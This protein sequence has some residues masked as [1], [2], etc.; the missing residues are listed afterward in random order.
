MKLLAIDCATDIASVAIADGKHRYYSEQSSLRQHALQLLPMIH[1]LLEQSQL[2]LSGLDG[3]VF[4]CGPGSFTGLRIG[5]AVAKALAYAHSLP[6]YPVCSIDA[7]VLAIRAEHP[8]DAILVAMDA[9][10][11]EL[12]WAFYPKDS[13][14]PIDSVAVG[15]MSSIKLASKEPILLAGYGLEPLESLWPKDLAQQFKH[16]YRIVPNA[17]T[18][19]EWVLQGRASPT[20]AAEALPLYVRSTVTQ[21]GGAHG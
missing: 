6:I 13:L 1:D 19:I 17:K 15:P 12:Y 14:T 2:Q 9:R 3:I 8:L 16:Q 7:M 5:C 21:S 20:T 4:D 11:Q 18:L 10:M